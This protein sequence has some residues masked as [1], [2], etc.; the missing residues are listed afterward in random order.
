MALFDSDT[1]KLAHQIRRTHN[2][3]WGESLRLAIKTVNLPE[4]GVQHPHS[5]FG[6]WSPFSVNAVAGHFYGLSKAYDE[7]GDAGR[8]I[9]FKKVSSTLYG[10]FENHEQITLSTLMHKKFFK[11]SVL[12]EIVDY[13]VASAGAG[14]TPRTVSLITERGA[15]MYGRKVRRAEWHF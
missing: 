5:I 13:F 14:F 3:T 6:L 1:M 2:L 4:Q 8:A 9:A 11:E 15:T 10:A 7:V 12:T